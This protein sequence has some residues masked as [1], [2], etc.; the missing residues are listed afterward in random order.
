ME[1]Q[2]PLLKSEAVAEMQRGIKVT[3]VCFSDYEYITRKHGKIVLEDRDKC[4][5]LEFLRY[6]QID[7]WNNGYAILT[8]L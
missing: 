3:N 1:D 4:H 8:N 7:V 6:K 2:Y 5:Q